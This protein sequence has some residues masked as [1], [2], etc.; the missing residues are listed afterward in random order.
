MTAATPSPAELAERRL[1][2]AALVPEGALAVVRGAPSP[3]TSR[4][5]RQTNEFFYVTG[6]EVPNAYVLVE[7]ASGR[8]TIYLPR[9]DEEL[10]RGEGR[11]LAAE[12]VDRVV[13]ATGADL[14]RPVDALAGDLGR[15]LFR[16]QS[17]VL[18]TPL[19]P[20]E[21]RRGSRDVLLGGARRLVDPFCDARSDED[22]FAAAL[23]AQFPQLEVRD[24][25]P[26]L[27]ELRSVKGAA[28]L[29]AL[30]EAARLCGV[31]VLEAMR[32]T[33]PGVYEYE[34][35][36][37]ADFIYV[38]GG[39]FGGAYE[40]I[41]ATGT[42]AWHGHYHAKQSALA[43]G[44]LVLMDYAPDYRY[45]TSDI[46]RI[47]P[48]SGRWEAWQL[49][50]YEFVVRYHRE[51]LARIAPGASAADVLDGARDTMETIVDETTFSK[52]AYER[53]AREA[54]AFRGH[55][56]HP[57]GMAVHDVGEYRD[58]PFVP[59]QVFS[60]DPMVWV[61]EE[62]LYVRCE[63]TVAVTTDGLENLT[64]FVPLDPDAIVRVMAEPGLLQTY[65]AA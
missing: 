47:W 5:F 65:L 35:A 55:L 21:G 15:R 16:R 50:L 3:R 10:E 32:S 31:A 44:E 45:Y 39:A 59:G 60:V 18:C 62:R 30:R 13:E 48:V 17:P 19:A 26:A 63:D 8:T 24:L 1:R 49:D 29:R 38:R 41:V 40:A 42:N 61:P 52:P 56:S 20:A 9:R 27:D 7:A 36:A 4:T 58:A 6:L 23:R 12:D 51:L 11:Q 46:G 53:A 37:L 25:S 57:V 34:L 14:V 54:L 33:A 43:A 2:L 28:E 64:G 22:A